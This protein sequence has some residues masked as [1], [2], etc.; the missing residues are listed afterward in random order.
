MAKT[1]QPLR[2]LSAPLRLSAVT[3]RGIGPYLHGARLEIKPLTI[4]CGE[5]GSGKSTWIEMLW[6][7]KQAAAADNFPRSD[8][9]QSPLQHVQR[10]PEEDD[11]DDDSNETDGSTF[12]RSQLHAAFMVL[13]SEVDDPDYKGKR[14][15]LRKL[16]LN[17]LSNPTDDSEYGPVGCIGL[18][19]QVV[20]SS[21]QLPNSISRLFQEFNLSPQEMVLRWANPSF[22]QA[23]N[24]YQA[25]GVEL[26]F[27]LWRWVEIVIDGNQFLRVREKVHPN[28]PLLKNDADSLFECSPIFEDQFDSGR[29]F[30]LFRDIVRLTLN[31]FYP[32]GPIRMI[33]HSESSEMSPTFRGILGKFADI[34]K[35]PFSELIHIQGDEQRHVGYWGEFAQDRYV[36]WAYNLMRQAVVPFT[37]NIENG[38]LSSDFDWTEHD[39]AEARCDSRRFD[40]YDDIQDE[41]RDSLLKL[42]GPK[43]KKEILDAKDDHLKRRALVIDGLNA[44][45]NNRNLYHDLFRGKANP[46]LDGEAKLLI[47]GGIEKLAADE[48]RRLNRL[49]LE[50]VYGRRTEP[51]FGSSKKKPIY[52]KNDPVCVHRT[53]YFVET[54]VSYWLRELTGTV[55]QYASFP[56]GTLDTLWQSLSSPPNG[57]LV[58]PERYQ[59]PSIGPYANRE[60]MNSSGNFH[61]LSRIIR[62][63]TAKSGAAW[64][65]MSTGFHQIAPLVVQAGLLHQ[66]EVM[67]VESPEAHLHPSLQ[68]KV[69]EFLMHQANAGKVMLIETHSDLFV[70]RVMRAIREEQVAPGNPFKQASVGITFTSLADDQTGIKFSKIEQ[71]AINDQGQIHNWPAGFMDDDLKE[72]DRWLTAVERQRSLNDDE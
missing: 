65:V 69:A 66:N 47:E 19:I 44:V 13:A 28:D 32:V 12:A 70:R 21:S 63:T 56:H 67:A 51:V 41:Y 22:P 71:L 4:L 37:G 29:L 6:R 3:L 48:V 14:D 26:P 49:L 17:E 46:E 36:S 25:L 23:R 40:P 31:G 24:K 33:H 35:E 20:T 52:H 8:I 38:F 5:N 53:G 72:A 11:D 62:P 61:D 15:E 54:F 58:E 9:D 68:I 57:G 1:A 55:I 43:M 7:L 60:A 64:H 42:F 45:L 10:N 18:T 39:Y 2:M 30:N 59:N 16:R 27:G 34:P 50:A